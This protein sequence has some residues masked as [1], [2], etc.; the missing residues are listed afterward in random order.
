MPFDKDGNELPLN[1]PS[2]YIA[3]YS[4][5]ELISGLENISKNTVRQFFPNL[6]KVVLNCNKESISAM[7]VEKK[8]SQYQIPIEIYEYVKTL[9][10]N[11]VNSFYH[12]TDYIKLGEPVVVFKTV[13]NPVFNMDTE[14]RREMLLIYI[15][16]CYI[17]RNFESNFMRNYTEKAIERIERKHKDDAALYDYYMY[18]NNDRHICINLSSI[19]DDIKAYKSEIIPKIQKYAKCAD[20]II[21]DTPQLLDTKDDIQHLQSSVTNL[22]TFIKFMKNSITSFET[23]LQLIN[24]IKTVGQD[25]N[26]YQ[27]MNKN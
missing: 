24:T 25:Y 2:E 20:K 22:K 21:S 7:N 17:K 23:S 8:Y 26:S 4:M 3:A 15:A 1:S 9:I 27:D 5:N 14:L 10:S 13:P 19:Q 11:K 12:I 6:L 16:V 18:F